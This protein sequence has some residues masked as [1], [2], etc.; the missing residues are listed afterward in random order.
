VGCNTR[1]KALSINRAADEW[2]GLKL[3]ENKAKLTA[4]TQC[5]H[6]VNAEARRALNTSAPPPRSLRLRGESD[7]PDTQLND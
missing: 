4:E 6:R 3:S 5:Q 1:F 7:S 2:V